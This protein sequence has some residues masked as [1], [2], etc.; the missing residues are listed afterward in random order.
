MTFLEFYEKYK[1]KYTDFDGYYGAQC[2]DL[3]QYWSREIGGPRFTG[4]AKDIIHQAGTF[5]DRIDNKLLNF[6]KEGDIVVWNEK[7]GAGFG[8]TGIAT[9]NAGVLKLEVFQQ[10]DPMRSTA[11]LKTYTYSNIIGW[12]HPKNQIP[13]LG[14]D[15]KILFESLVTGIRAANAATEKLIIQLGG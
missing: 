3:V 5:Y 12:L 15:Y 6:P 13:N 11:Q 2:V 7:M 8:H 10:N 1:N 9:K 14:E 4:N